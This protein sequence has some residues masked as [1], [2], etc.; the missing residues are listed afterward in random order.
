MS[1]DEYRQFCCRV[2][3]DL[4]LIIFWRILS[5]TIVRLIERKRRRGDVRERKGDV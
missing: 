5:V 2:A 4:S 3:V 1:S